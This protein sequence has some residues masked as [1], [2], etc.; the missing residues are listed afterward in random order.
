MPGTLPGV[1]ILAGVQ[2]MD[3]SYH[4]ALVVGGRAVE[5]EHL[6]VLSGTVTPTRSLRSSWG[7]QLVDASVD[8]GLESLLQSATLR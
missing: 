6:V 2:T 4:A 3:A 8:G 1:R 7:F 5:Q